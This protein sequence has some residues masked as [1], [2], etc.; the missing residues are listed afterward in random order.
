MLEI[1]KRRFREEISLEDYN[2]KANII[3]T[4]IE[5]LNKEKA[6]LETQ[7]HSVRMTRK[8]VED[9][10][11]FLGDINPTKNFDVE[12][13]KIFVENVLIKPNDEIEFNFKAG[14]SHSFKLK[15]RK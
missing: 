7:V 4:S 6:I 2:K 15:S 3:S 9:I 14:I 1:H 5:Q 10:L 13:F 8:R 12:L 11:E